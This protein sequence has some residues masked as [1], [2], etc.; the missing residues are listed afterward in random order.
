MGV[1]GC[2][3]TGWL[4]GLCPGY[5]GGACWPGGPRIPICNGTAGKRSHGGTAGNARA[6]GHPHA[7]EFL[8]RLCAK[9]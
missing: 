5:G 7:M 3:M 6:P 2:C 4:A 9:A 1:L 8:V